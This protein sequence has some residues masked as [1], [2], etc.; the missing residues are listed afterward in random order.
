MRKKELIEARVVR[1]LDMFVN[2]RTSQRAPCQDDPER[3]RIM[4][5]A[6]FSVWSEDTLASYLQDVNEAAEKRMNL[7]ALKYARMDN[8]IPEL[9]DNP[10]IDDIVGIQLQGQKDLSAKYPYLMSRGRP[11]DESEDGRLISFVTYLRC[12]LETHS[13][14]TL[15]SL[16]RDLI[17]HKRKGVNIAAEIYRSMA[18]GLGFESIEQAEEEIR[19]QAP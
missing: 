7:M 14:K 11:L 16:H 15:A 9:N 19:R 4:R 12:E 6:Q 8:L 2:L 3:F 10:L 17:E 1:E 18:E 13:D 5:A